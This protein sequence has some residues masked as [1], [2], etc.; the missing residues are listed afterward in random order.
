VTEIQNKEKSEVPKSIPAFLRFTLMKILTKKR[1]WLLLYWLLLVLVGI[2][3]VLL[4]S[5]HL[6]PAIYIAI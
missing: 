1:Y 5:G 4:G 2:V 6:L 3:L